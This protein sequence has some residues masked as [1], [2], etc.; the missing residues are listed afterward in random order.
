MSDYSAHQQRIDKKLHEAGNGLLKLRD[1]SKLPR[2]VQRI[3]VNFDHWQGTALLQES[4]ALADGGVTGSARME[5]PPGF[6]RTMIKEALSDL[7]ILDL[8]EIYANP[9]AQATTLIPYETR[10]GAEIL[11]GGIVYEN[12]PI[13]RVGITQNLWIASIHASK[14]SLLV[15]NEIQFLTSA[16]GP[17]FAAME[18]NI[19]SNARIIQEAICQRIANEMQ[20]AADAYNAV[21]V[22]GEDL[23]SQ[24]DGETS[25][26]KT[27][28]FPIV[29]PYQERDLR[30]NAMGDPENPLALVINGVAISPYSGTGTQAPGTYYRL[31]SLNL[32]LIRLVDQTGQPVTPT[33]SAACTLSYSYA[34]N[35]K[36]FDL[37]A[38]AGVEAYIH[39]DGALRV[40]GEAR[41]MLLEKRWVCVD[42]ALMSPTLN[43]LLSGARGFMQSKVRFGTALDG[44]GDL[45]VIHGIPCYA[46]NVPC[47]LGAERILLGERGTLRY[48]IAKPFMTGMPFEAQ[49]P[50]G[51]IGAKIAYGEEYSAVC[52]PAPVRKNLTSVILFDSDARAAAA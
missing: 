29:R 9:S 42:Y 31:E 19:V 38:P 47:D 7:A 30:G 24:C 21:S 13:P 37:K 26:I 14:I 36:K 8:I 5:I 27:A 18:R 25:L 46:T 50:N 3:L 51:P 2:G 35:V 32:G 16:L 39:L 6:Q 20:R 28:H 48:V 49:G 45:D 52:V 41:A 23:S 11:N 22:T 1:E 17:E 34:T 4:R 44:R 33:A 40:L 15:S 12:N 10:E 43:V